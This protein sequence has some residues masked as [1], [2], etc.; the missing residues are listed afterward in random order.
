[1]TSDHMTTGG[2]RD[3]FTTLITLG[4]LAHASELVLQEKDFIWKSVQ[5]YTKQKIQ[6]YSVMC[7]CNLYTLKSERFL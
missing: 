6:K 7:T 5:K 1:M 3:P 4:L 2:A